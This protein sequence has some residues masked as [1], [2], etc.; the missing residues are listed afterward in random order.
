VDYGGDSDTSYW[1]NC[2]KCNAN[3]PV[4]RPGRSAL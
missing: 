1:I 4:K 3:I 2:P